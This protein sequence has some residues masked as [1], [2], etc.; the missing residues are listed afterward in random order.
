MVIITAAQNFNTR[1]DVRERYYTD[2]AGTL[3]EL[4]G[5]AKNYYLCE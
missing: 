2:S 1:R 4:F 3:L 5:Q